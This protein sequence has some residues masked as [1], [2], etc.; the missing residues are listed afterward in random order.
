MCLNSSSRDR[1]RGDEAESR[2]RWLPMAAGADRTLPPSNEGVRG[3]RFETL[4]R[5]SRT[6]SLPGWRSVAGP[7]YEEFGL[8]LVRDEPLCESASQALICP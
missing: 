1:D 8:P 7:D 2:F 3:I 5:W 4:T 6:T